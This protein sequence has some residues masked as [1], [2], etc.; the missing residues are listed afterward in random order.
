M[1][2]KTTLPRPS[3]AVGINSQKEIRCCAI[4]R[5]DAPHHEARP[6]KRRYEAIILAHQAETT[7]ALDGPEEARDPAK[8]AVALSRETGAGFCGPLALSILARA[9]D[10]AA[11]R[12]AALHEGETILARGCASHNYFWFH[13]NAVELALDWRNWD[14]ADRHA[15]ALIA[16]TQAERLPFSDLLAAR[17][18]ALAAFGRGAR[19]TALLATLSTLRDE[20]LTAGVR[21][22]LPALDAALS[23]G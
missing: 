11:E 5:D 2:Q 16:Y 17:G 4:E 3:V 18:H 21:M 6:L 10:D 8:Q 20:A 14:E 19:N 9:T 1:A 12:M 22:A 13:R 23:A 7:L 15:D